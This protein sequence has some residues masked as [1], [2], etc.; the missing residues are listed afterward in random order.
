MRIVAATLLGLLV[1][2]GLGAPSAQPEFTQEPS[3]G[4]RLRVRFESVD[5]Y[6]QTEGKPLAAYQLDLRATEG[7]VKIVGIEGGEHAAFSNPPYY[8]TAAMQQDHVIIAAFSTAKAELLPTGR[9]RIATIHVQI[10]GAQEPKFAT[11]LTVAAT[12]DGAAIPATI[13]LVSSIAAPA[14]AGQKQ[15]APADQSQ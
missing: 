4:D 14:D 13:S 10:T 11:E 3:N 15:S 9:T 5:V 8:D 12:V 2:A 7:D 6:V 1:L